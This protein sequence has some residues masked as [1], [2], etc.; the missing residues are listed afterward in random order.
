MA[1]NVDSY[2]QNKKIRA[3]KEW[4]IENKQRETS[5]KLAGI[6][7]H[8]P[9]ERYQDYKESVK[10]ARVTY[11]LPHAPAM[12]CIDAAYLSRQDATPSVMGPTKRPHQDHAADVGTASEEYYALVH[13]PVPMN[14]VSDNPD[15]KG[16]N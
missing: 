5:R 4:A 1:R 13:T 11:Q 2:V 14:Q 15:A 10:Y 7:K 9:A 12:P 3:I 6:T 16:T 8:V